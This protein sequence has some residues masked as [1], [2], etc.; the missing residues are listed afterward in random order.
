VVGAGVVCAT[1]DAGAVPALLGWDRE[2]GIELRAVV[3]GWADR[4]A[5]A[6]VD[7][8]APLG[9]ATGWLTI[10][11]FAGFTSGWAIT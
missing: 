1:E 10:A 7:G 3:P 2:I 5:P 11:L 8:G 6:K 9:A 4:V